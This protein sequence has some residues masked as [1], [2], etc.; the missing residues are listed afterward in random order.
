MEILDST[1]RE[2]EQTPRVN[3]SVDEK[4]EIANLLD[5]FG[6]DIIEIGHPTVSDDVR[7][8]CEAITS[9]YL[10]SDTLGHARAKKSDID[11]VLDVDADWIGIFLGTSQISQKHNTHLGREETLETIANSVEYAKDHG[12]K[13]RFTPEDATRTEWDYLSE[14]LTVAEDAGAD[15]VS[16]ADTVGT[17]R[18]QNMYELTDKVVNHVDIPVHVHCHNDYGMAVANALSAYDAGAYLID[19]T[20]NGLGERTGIT[21]LAPLTVA[22]TRLYNVDKDWNLKALP[23][24]SRKVEKYSGLYNSE[25]APIVGDYAFS[26]KAGVHTKAVI[27]DPE[28]YEAIPP[29]IVNQQRNIII[30]KYTGKTAV[31]NRLEKMGIELEEKQL[32]KIVHKVKKESGEGKRRFTDVDLLEIADKVLDLKIESRNPT[33]VEAIVS[34]ILESGSYTTRTTRKL[35]S[36]EETEQVFELTGEK[37]ILAHLK[38]DT[39]QQLNDTI[40]ELRN[41]EEIQKTTTSIILK[42]YEYNDEETQE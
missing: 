26:H 13:V 7:E 12:L 36:L 31:K 6:V 25:Q 3:F 4:I 8:A 39:I 11:D 16:I 30:D 18:P 40:E 37:D 38:V 17:M 2:G 5:E 41:L 15:R 1:L 19:V 32:N 23:K 21:P 27:E 42:D 20:V 9:E 29:E 33:K 22:L 24:I 14:V 35:I 34:F 28:T 10:D